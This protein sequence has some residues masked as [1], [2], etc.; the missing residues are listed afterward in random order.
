MSIAVLVSYGG[1]NKVL[2]INKSHDASP[3]HLLI[4]EF[5]NKFFEGDHN[6]NVIFQKFDCDWEEYVNV[7]MSDDI[8]NKDKLK[9]IVVSQNKDVH[10]SIKETENDSCTPTRSPSHSRKRKLDFQSQYSPASWEQTI[11]DIAQGLDNT[12]HIFDIGSDIEVKTKKK[13]HKVEEDMIPLPDPFPLPKHHK[14]DVEV[15]L[16]QHKM[17][18][19]TRRQFISDVASTILG[20]K[21][22][23]TKEDYTNVARTIISTQPFL[24]APPG[25]GTPLGVIV[26]ELKSHFKEFRRSSN[27]SPCSSSDNTTTSRPRKNP[28][29][30]YSTET[31]VVPEGEDEF[32]FKLHQRTLQAEYQKKNPNVGVVYRLMELSFSMRRIDIIEKGYSGVN[33]LFCEYPFLQEYDH[34]IAEMC[35]NLQKKSSFVEEALKAWTTSANVILLQA[36]VEAQ[37]S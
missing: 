28:G 26:E 17:S 9:A 7:T 33:A 27:P 12:D 15:A 21:R 3:L 8:A 30:T 19:T 23:P 24:R 31:P 2:K 1:S 6:V 20:Y 25:A 34:L 13:V 35:R 10:I 14:S 29:I 32:S 18:S 11:L 22:Y 37:H 5:Q 36:Q 4:E 16:K